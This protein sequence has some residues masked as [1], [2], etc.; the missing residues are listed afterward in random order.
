MPVSPRHP[1][2]ALAEYYQSSDFVV[3]AKKRVVDLRLLADDGPFSAGDGPLVSGTTLALTR[4]MTGR[5]AYCDELEG[6]G[7]A[8]LRERCDTM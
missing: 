7:V 1:V 6:D 4:A 3:V 5:A 2:T 8:I